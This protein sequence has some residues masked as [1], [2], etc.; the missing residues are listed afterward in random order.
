M[1]IVCMILQY[2]RNKIE[3]SKIS[4]LLQ[5]ACITFPAYF[6]IVTLVYYAH[7]RLHYVMSLLL[8]NSTLTSEKH[9]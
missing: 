6:R 3:N 4:Y 7:V 2:P 8:Y 9:N 5:V 1:V